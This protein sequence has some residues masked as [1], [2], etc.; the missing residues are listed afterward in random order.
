MSSSRFWSDA[1]V[2]PKRSFRWYL[3]LAGASNNNKIESYA[4]KTVKKP[5]FA[6]SEIPHQYVAHTFYY[7]GR[8]TWNTIDVTFVDPISPDQSS[9]MANMLVTS[10]YTP[11]TTE[12][13]SRGSM[14]KFSFKEAIGSPRITQVDAE[15]T[16]LEYWDLHNAF[17]TSVDFGQLDY[18]SEELTILSVTLRFDFATLTSAVGVAPPSQLILGSE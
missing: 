5:S 12:E 4:V 8:I 3:T 9:V 17:F 7:P 6:I 2:E 10:G 1:S 13:K 18:S 15:G 16:D 11:P 14:S